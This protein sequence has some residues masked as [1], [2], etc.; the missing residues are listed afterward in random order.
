MPA[1]RLRANPCND[2]PTFFPLALYNLCNIGAINTLY[3][4]MS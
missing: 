3:T 4:C 2:V 1:N